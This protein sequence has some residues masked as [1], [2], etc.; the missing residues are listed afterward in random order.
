MFLK[1]FTFLFFTSVNVFDLFLILFSV[2][3]FNLMYIIRVIILVNVIE[4]VNKVNESKLS[5][6]F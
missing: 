1:H 4:F 6:Y 3:D 5:R 2:F